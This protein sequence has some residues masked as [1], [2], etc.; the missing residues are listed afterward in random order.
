[1]ILGFDYQL[2]L[3]YENL[4]IKL[5]KIQQGTHTVLCTFSIL[6]Q[7][8]FQICNIFLTSIVRH[9]G[10]YLNCGWVLG[11]HLSPLLL[12][13]AQTRWPKAF[14]PRPASHLGKYELQGVWTQANYG[15]PIGTGKG[16]GDVFLE[17]SAI[18]SI[19]CAL[20]DLPWSCSYWESLPSVK[21]HCRLY[22]ETFM[23]NIIID[24]QNKKNIKH[25]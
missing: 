25:H 22:R 7:L 8:F 12:Q 9:S 14:L 10:L 23:D 5:H 18:Q 19:L 3:T 24:L 11:L 13:T 17:W 20:C 21:G 16:T 1:M 6:I 15:P 4:K 2:A